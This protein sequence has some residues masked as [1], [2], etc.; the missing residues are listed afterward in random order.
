MSYWFV[1]GN[2]VR[3]IHDKQI[4]ALRQKNKN[5]QSDFDVA[6]YLLTTTSVEFTCLSIVDNHE[7]KSIKVRFSDQLKTAFPSVFNVSTPTN[8]TDTKMVLLSYAE[9]TKALLDSLPGV[10]DFKDIIVFK[11]LDLK[12]MAEDIQERA[13]VTPEQKLNLGNGQT[14]PVGGPKHAASL[15]DLA[16]NIG[17]MRGNNVETAQKKSSDDGRAIITHVV[18][19]L[20]VVSKAKNSN[21]AVTF[22]RI[23]K[24]FPTIAFKALKS[25]IGKKP[26]DTVEMIASHPISFQMIPQTEFLDY[27]MHFLV[28]Q[29]KLDRLYGGNT[30]LS[31]LWKYMVAGYNSTMNPMADRNNQ[32]G[33]IAVFK[34]G[35]LLLETAQDRTDLVMIIQ[36]ITENSAKSL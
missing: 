35:D 30:S 4:K 10:L 24:C 9:F 25:G 12:K 7:Q 15:V 19:V 31:L 6:K 21:S 22:D 8:T 20:H 1:N 18:Q 26:W 17:L 27:A 13:T 14:V 29:Q 36:R 33:I 2:F 5:L 3:L 11:G 34:E 16:I 23:I 28:V 32:H